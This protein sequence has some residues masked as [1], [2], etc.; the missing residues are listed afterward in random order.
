MK[1]FLDARLRRGRLS[2]LATP[3]ARLQGVGNE[4]MQI[5]GGMP[6]RDTAKRPSLA[7]RMLDTGNA[8][9]LAGT[10]AGRLSRCC[11][12]PVIVRGIDHAESM[13]Q[14]LLA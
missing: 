14:W 4:K 7:R 2:L 3:P 6:R 13:P 10:E 1:A 12:R 8:V 5:A 11:K 9:H